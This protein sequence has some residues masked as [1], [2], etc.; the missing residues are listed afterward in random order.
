MSNITQHASREQYLWLVEHGALK[1]LSSVLVMN[2]PRILIVAMEAIEN[3]FKMGAKEFINEEGQNSFA[4]EFELCGGVDR[5]EEL[6]LH[7]NH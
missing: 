6:Q 5:I 1:A 7:K 3:I 2:E 4:H